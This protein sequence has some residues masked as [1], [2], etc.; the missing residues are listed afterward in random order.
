M[1]IWNSNYYRDYR[2]TFSERVL[3]NP[4]YAAKLEIVICGQ[5]QVF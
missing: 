1:I 4:K 5:K 2:D 3:V